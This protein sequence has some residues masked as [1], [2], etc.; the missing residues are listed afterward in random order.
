MVAGEHLLKPEGILPTCASIA[1]GIGFVSL[2][3]Y[4]VATWEEAPAF[5]DK[6]SAKPQPLDVCRQLRPVVLVSV[7]WAL[8][9]Y[10]F[11]QGQAAAAFWVHR[12]RREAGKKN[13]DPTSP[14]GQKSD[15]KILTFAEV[16]YGPMNKNVGMILT[17]DRSVGNMLEQTAPFLL[18]LWL[19]A[20]VA[21]ADNAAWHGWLWLL[22]RA[23]YPVAFAHPSMSPALWGI[24]RRVGISWVSMVTWPQYFIVWK[25][26]VGSVQACW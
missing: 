8:L 7:G 12:H 24:Q 3:A 16:K 18:G 2:F 13:D 23:L 25:L 9:Y 15:Q 22:L 19:H 6:P 20:L 21:S 10:C 17:M 1:Y 5:F 14:P 26:L 4:A 11:L